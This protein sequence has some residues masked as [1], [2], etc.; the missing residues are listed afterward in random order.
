[1]LREELARQ[2][3]IAAARRARHALT[4]AAVCHREEGGG[5]PVEEKGRVRPCIVCRGEIEEG[6]RIITFGLS[7][8]PKVWNRVEA[9]IGGGCDQRP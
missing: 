6:R 7:P 8:W 5:G 1:M 9:A 4:S 3:A 2:G